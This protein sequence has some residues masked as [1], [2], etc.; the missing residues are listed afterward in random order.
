MEKLT[1]EDWAEVYYALDYKLTSAAVA[2]DR[3]WRQH[4]KSIMRKIGPDGSN[5]VAS[6]VPETTG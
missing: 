2:S 1:A 3:R 4:I 5:M 6:K